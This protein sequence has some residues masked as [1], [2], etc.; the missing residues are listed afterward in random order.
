MSTHPNLLDSHNSLLVIVDMQ[1]KL[2][3]AM[4]EKDVAIMTK[5]GISLLMA[6]KLLGVPVFMTEQYPKGLGATMLEIAENLPANT[7]MFEKTGFSCCAA[8]GFK[9]ALAA[10][11]RRQIILAGQEA[12]VCILQTALELLHMGYLVYVVEDA[13]CSRQTQHKISALHRM[14]RNGVTVVC[15]ESVLFEWLKDA[16]HADFKAISSLLR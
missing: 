7:R 8:D 6:S 10:S 4:P 13:L 16:K 3:A 1:S 9:Q 14:Q 5:N 2:S 11:G 15:H 12:H